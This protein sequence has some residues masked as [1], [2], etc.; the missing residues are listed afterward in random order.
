M[1]VSDLIDEVLRKEGGYVN[2]PADRGGP[3]KFGITQRTLS[4]WL[5]RPVS[6]E[7]V[8]TLDVDT[9]REIYEQNYYTAPRIDTLPEEI[10]PLVFDCAVNHGPR[11]AISF[12][13][14]VINEAGF[15]PIDIDGTLGPQTR[16]AA[17][18]AQQEMEGFFCNAIVEE[19]LTFYETLA[20]D[21]SQAPFIRGWRAR[22]ESFRVPV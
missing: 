9:A 11:R 12:V 3:T 20:L 21:R 15:G 19:R 8:R 14:R 13:Q 10:Q 4:T 5:G 16:A 2:H 22:A 18:V 7:E 17:E 6:A 1:L